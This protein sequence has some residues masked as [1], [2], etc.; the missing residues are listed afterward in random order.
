ME[1]VADLVIVMVLLSAI[2]I[3]IARGLWG[4]L[5]T[6]GAFI[7]GFIVDVKLVMPILGAVIPLGPVR[8]IVGVIVFF[9]I[10]I[11][12]RFL[13]KPLYVILQRLPIT[14]HVDAPAGAVVHGLVGFTLIYLLL[15]VILDFDRN[16]YPMVAAGVATAQQINDYQQAI[17]DRP[18]L[19]GIVDEAQLK[20]AQA[21]AQ[22]KPIPEDALRKAE[23]FLDF[24]VA[25]IR[26]PLIDSRL[27]P[28]I[29]RV[30]EKLP[31]VGQPR[32][33]MTGAKHAE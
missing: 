33:Y 13:A 19:N 28:I 26:A 7:F 12:I 21:Q 24:Y 8:T 18:Y 14:R 4:P 27:A 5:L 17:N 6:E 32:P 23:K 2:Y 30:G 10:G 29:N 20:Q 3:G 22:A 16:V 9:V 15:G 25:N 11:A 31:V 1:F